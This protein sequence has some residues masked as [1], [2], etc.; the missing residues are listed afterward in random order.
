MTIK[1]I[2]VE[3]EGDGEKAL[4][5]IDELLDIGSLQEELAE[6]A[7]D[8]EYQVVSALA[9]YGNAKFVARLLQRA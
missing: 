4:S 9:R 5:V 7:D 2:I 1:I 8:G 6:C 3:I